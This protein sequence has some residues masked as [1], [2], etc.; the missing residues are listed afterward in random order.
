MYLE[1][2]DCTALGAT[3]VKRRIRRGSY[4]LDGRDQAD[5]YCLEPS[6]GGWAVFF[7]ERGERNDESWF[8]SEDEACDDLLRRILEDP[9]TRQR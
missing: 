7:A 4:S 2:M 3:L 8:E 5:R 1:R 6:D 9:T